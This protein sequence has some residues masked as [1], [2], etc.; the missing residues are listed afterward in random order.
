LPPIEQPTEIHT[1]RPTVAATTAARGWPIT[2]L[3][4]THDIEGWAD[5]VSVSPGDGV[6]L[7]VSTVS[8]TFSVKA[9]RM[10]WY[11]GAQATE[12]WHVDNVPGKEQSD[13]VL[14]DDTNTVSTRWSPS[15]LIPTTGWPAGAYLFRL[16]AAGGA[17]RYVPLTVRGPTAEGKVVIVNAVTTWQAYNAWGGRSLY[18]G[19]DGGGD[20]AGR[21]RA[22]SFD[23]PYA[24]D[25]SGDFIGNELPLIALA[26]KLQLPLDYVTD[27]DLHANP[28]LLFGARAIITLGHD[29]YW[30]TAMRSAVTAARDRG[31]NVAFLGA[32]AMFRHIR[33][34]TTRIGPNRLE[35]GYKVASE[36]PLLR[37]DPAE[38]TTNWREPPIGRPESDLTGVYYE[39]NP[40]KADFVIT[41]ASN[42]LFATAGV[43]NGTKLPGLV[44]SEYDRVNPGAP[45]PRPI[46]VLAHSPVRCRGIA[47]YSD[48]AY[49][50]TTSGAGVF[51]SGTSAWVAALTGCQATECTLSGRV[52]TE[53]TTTLL[54]AFAA[55]PAARAHPAIDNLDALH[56]F[57]GDPIAAGQRAASASSA[58]TEAD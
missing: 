53:V 56:A 13:P 40:V 1:P 45:T 47:S 15:V 9:F 50:T 35:I 11:N 30:S 34:G 20:F 57:K 46:E 54:R 5:Q 17:Q 14:D 41:D 25:G 6:R 31:S 42:W 27:V 4:K 51:A 52:V 24:G 36:D 26:E 43:Q 7:Y 18:H 32:N 58:T 38:V 16:D 22:V 28:L 33:F 44:G 48:A 8:P 29:E 19:P 23:R 39:C 21:A 3:G 12:V 49:Y 37:S 55:G 10:G 2:N